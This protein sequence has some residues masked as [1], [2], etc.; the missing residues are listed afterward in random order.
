MD[1]G[2]EER[3]LTYTQG[4]QIAFESMGL[5]SCVAFFL[6][7]THSSSI[8]VDLSLSPFALSLPL[9]LSE[10]VPAGVNDTAAAA[11]FDAVDIM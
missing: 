9:S 5:V 1:E 2:K 4:D 10:V 7:S 6:T 8:F 3:E 11:R